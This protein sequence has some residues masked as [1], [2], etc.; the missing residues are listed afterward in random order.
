MS[1]KVNPGTV[2]RKWRG[3]FPAQFPSIYPESARFIEFPYFS[4]LAL[5]LITHFFP[6]L[7][8][9]SGQDYDL[10]AICSRAHFLSNH[11]LSEERDGGKLIESPWEEDLNV[12]V[13]YLRWSACV[14]PIRDAYLRILL[15]AVAGNCNIS[16]FLSLLP[17]TL[18][19]PL[20]MG[21]WEGRNRMA[22]QPTTSVAVRV[23]HSALGLFGEFNKGVGRI[24]RRQENIKL[25]LS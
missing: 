19:A 12:E 7:F 4:I 11:H 15:E 16:F 25:V 6:C 24:S 17:H 20:I 9:F 13:Y 14:I 1:T 10:L 3:T 22:W 5:C 8:R 18:E 2:D 21:R 23:Q